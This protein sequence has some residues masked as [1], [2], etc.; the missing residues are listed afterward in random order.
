MLSSIKELKT[1][2]IIFPDHIARHI[3]QEQLIAT[4][5]IKNNE[6]LNLKVHKV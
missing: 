4:N 5:V 6:Y 3:F 1:L 2:S